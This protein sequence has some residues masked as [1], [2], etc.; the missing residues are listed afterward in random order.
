MVLYFLSSAE[1][2]I[3][4][5]FAV[6]IN[7]CSLYPEREA[8]AIDNLLQELK[9]SNYLSHSVKNSELELPDAPKATFEFHLFEYTE[10]QYR[11]AKALVEL[12]YANLGIGE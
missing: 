2:P 5:K 7:L 6:S 3:N 11:I 8:T 10:E 9:A 1:D 4:C 12:T